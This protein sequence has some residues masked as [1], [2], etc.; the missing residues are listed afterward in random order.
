MDY[1]VPVDHRVKIKES[2]KM[3]KYLDFD[4]ELK[5]MWNMRMT[6]IPIVVGAFETVFKDLEKGL[7]E[8]EIGGRIQ[9]INTTVFVENTEKSPGDLRRLAVTQIPVKVHQR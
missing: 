9:T 7:E 5:N 4:R 8:L 2:E 3:H 1:T 6:L